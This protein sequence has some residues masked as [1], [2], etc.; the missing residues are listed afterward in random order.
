MQVTDVRA[1]FKASSCLSLSLLFCFCWQLKPCVPSTSTATRAPEHVSPLNYHSS[2][3]IL[4]KQTAQL[5]SPCSSAPAKAA[6]CFDGK[7]ALCRTRKECMKAATM[8]PGTLIMIE[9][10]ADCQEE[11]RGCF[12]GGD[13]GAWPC[14]CVYA[15]REGALLSQRGVERRGGQCSTLHPTTQACTLS[16]HARL[17]AHKL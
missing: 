11:Q 6:D 16:R 8:H 17:N 13:G 10:S 1:R 7:D 4:L 12:C 2:I 9:S 15:G 3:I 14:C 5:L